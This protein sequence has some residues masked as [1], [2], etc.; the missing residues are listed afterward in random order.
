[1][2]ET[3]QLNLDLNDDKIKIVHQLLADPKKKFIIVDGVIGA[4][5]TTVIS[6]IEKIIFH[7]FQLYPK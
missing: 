2:S 7:H 3:I 4:G 1:M 6:L 5:K